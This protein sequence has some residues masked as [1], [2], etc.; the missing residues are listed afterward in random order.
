MNGSE[1]YECHITIDSTE[2]DDVQTWV[3]LI[4][5]RFSRIEGDPQLGK[6]TRC[7]ATQLYHQREVAIKFTDAAAYF[8]RSKGFH[9]LRCKVEH[10]IYDVHEEFTKK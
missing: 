9:V 5:W 4:H 7:Y 10:V 8:L 1:D 3:E 2:P 6:G